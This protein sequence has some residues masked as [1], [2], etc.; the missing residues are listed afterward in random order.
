M[1]TLEYVKER[2]T[3]AYNRVNIS[4]EE[5][6]AKRN[7]GT[8]VD[9]AYAIKAGDLLGTIEVLLELMNEES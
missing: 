2:L 7:D 3:L 6:I 5:Y 1:I 4:N 8:T 9:M